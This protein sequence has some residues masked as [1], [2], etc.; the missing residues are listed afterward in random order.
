MEPFDVALVYFGLL[1]SVALTVAIAYG[2]MKMSRD[3]ASLFQLIEQHTLEFQAQQEMNDVVVE[4]IKLILDALANIKEV[5]PRVKEDLKRLTN[6]YVSKGY[7]KELYWD[8]L[9]LKLRNLYVLGKLTEEDI[10]LKL[11]GGIEQ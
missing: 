1:I 5:P 9:H 2:C 3:L 7:G 4:N 6:L 8:D 11:N 10:N